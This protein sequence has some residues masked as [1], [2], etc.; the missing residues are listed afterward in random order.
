MNTHDFLLTI[1]YITVSVLFIEICIVFLRW[2]NSIHSYLFL[3]CMSSFISNIGYLMELEA[4]TEEAYLTALKLSYAGRVWIAFTFFMFS[5]KMCRIKIPKGLV[6]FLVA[7]HTGIYISVLTIG[8]N[9]LYY[10]DYQFVP[11]PVFPKFYRVNGSLHDLLM[12][13]NVI[14]IVIATTWVVK[15]FRQEKNKT[16]K[17]RL[18]MLLL[19]I[20]SQASAFLLHVT[21]IFSIS[22]YY[23][24][25]ML[26]ALFGTIFMLVGIFA[27]DLLGTREIARDFVIDR[28]S[29]GIIAVDHDGRIQYYNEPAAG[30]YPELDN[31]FLKT[32]GEDIVS[33][34]L[35]HDRGP[36]KTLA[37]HSRTP[38]DI[39][40]EIDDAATKGE[41]LKIKDRIYTPEKSE[42]LYKGENYGRLYALVDDTEHYEYMEELQK[43]R[44]I[45]DSAN[46]AKSTFLANMSHEIRTPINAVLGMDEMIL[47]ESG[48]DTIRSYAADIMSAGRTLLSLINDILDLSKVEAGKMEIIP[49]QYDLSSLINDLVN[50]IRGRAEN[51]GLGFNITVDGH[52]P[53]LLIGDEIRI[54][55]CAMNLLT[56]AV[57]YTETGEVTL[58]I[59]YEKKSEDAIGLS[60]TVEDTGIGMKP[61]DMEN[62]FS[63]YKRIEE[64]RNRF[65]EGTGLGMSITRQLLDLMGSTLQVQSEYG[66]GTVFS[67]SIDQ[68][69]VKWE[70]IGDVTKRLGD[71]QKK[72]YHYR[73]LFHAPGARILVVDDT[74]MNLTVI[75]SLLKKT[76][77][78]IDTA[79]SGKDACR[80]AAATKYDA[81]FIDHMMAEMDGVETLTNI[82]KA[83]MSKDAPAVALTAN[84]VSGA[85]EMYLGAGFTDYLSKPVDGMKLERMLYE[86]L[87]DEK[88][89]PVESDGDFQEDKNSVSEDEGKAVLPG[90]LKSIDELDWQKGLENCGS[91]EGY[92]SV[93]SV[94]HSTAGYKA[95]EI[96]ELWRKGNIADYTIKVHALKSSARII[97]AESLSELARTLEDAGKAGDNEAI[98]EHTARLLD[99]YRA[100]SHKLDRLDEKDESLPV[101]DAQALKEAYGSI[102]EIAGSMDYEMMED[103]LKNI[104]SYALPDPDR[105]KIAK[106][107]R[108]LTELDWDS[109]IKTA[110]EAL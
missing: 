107:E 76:R 67:F 5:A 26:G 43:Q 65:I 36:V 75:M 35:S 55:Q 3:T 92:I 84:A 81:I 97:G 2:K 91:E 28:I 13:L 79:M 101:I 40:T 18:L 19:A 100:L 78:M 50:L 96:E 69:V 41:T 89:L 22:G 53:H 15:A 83:G 45:A 25:T 74:E 12:G 88:I 104:R 14:F 60:I 90:W 49:V 95:E 105:E 87:P 59:A 68:T 30:L 98:Q 85:R 24:L 39:L 11:D 20:L 54:R 56:N 82:R 72:D 33:H 48:E 77:I 46:E 93:L 6:T 106:I 109:I 62:L 103:I 4:Q 16:S 21:G 32:G 57:K 7:L 34:V 29:E 94:F 61:E 58:K 99:M 17:Q 31:F 70:E 86:L 73:E 102:A 64:K 108:M 42:L 66:K 52:I 9:S 27:F 51:K 110:K 10:T 71:A 8:S 1:Q 80:M 23:D 38:Y 44:D 47:R 37:K 63:P